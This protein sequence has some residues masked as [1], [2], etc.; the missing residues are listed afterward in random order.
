MR[1]DERARVPHSHPVLTLNT[2]PHYLN[3]D[4]L[5]LA[6][7]LHEQL[8]RFVA[9]RGKQQRAA[10]RELRERYPDTPAA[11]PDGAGNARSS[12]L[13]YVVCYLEYVA[14]MEVAGADEA[15]RVLDFWTTHHYTAIYRRVLDD[16]DAIG[17][18]VERHGLMP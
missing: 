12:Y 11:P 14:L 13:H 4:G 5:L 6:T 10:L 16:A 7:Y 9:R 3:D 17:A 8:H 18:I 1:I 2:A 15:R